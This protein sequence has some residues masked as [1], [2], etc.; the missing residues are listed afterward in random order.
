VQG[1]TVI[2]DAVVSGETA[3]FSTSIS[4]DFTFMNDEGIDEQTGSYQNKTT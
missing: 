1:V 3:S 4:G 2:G